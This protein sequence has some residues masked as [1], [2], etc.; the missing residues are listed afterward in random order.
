VVLPKP[1]KPTAAAPN[2]PL[3]Q[4][5]DLQLTASNITGASYNW[6]GPSAYAANVQ[7]PVRANV[8]MGDAGAYYVYATVSG[9]V[10]DTDSVVVVVN[11]DPV[12]NVFPTPGASICQGKQ[13]IFTAIPTN[14]G[15]SPSYNWLVNGTATGSIGTTYSTTTLDNGDA[16]SCAM[17]STGTCATPFIDTS[18]AITMTVQPILTP[19]VT[20]TADNM[21]P[22]NGGLT[23]TFTAT[24]THGGANPEYQWKR[25][26]ADVVGATGATWGVIVNALNANEDICVVLKSS[27]E[28]AVP[29]TALSNCITTAFTG[30]GDI[31]NSKNIKI[32]PNPVKGKVIITSTERIE[33]VEISN[34]L[35]QKL[36]TKYNTTTTMQIDMSGFVGGVYI[37]KVNDS[38]I[39]RLVKE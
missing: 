38:Y 36:L 9:C 27:Y 12:V 17:T 19:T 21:P 3:C 35:G 39:S 37:I 22:W 8:Q 7:N 6:Y 1:A 24:P 31:V 5:Q 33:K 4:R 11:T 29:D 23:V 2:S 28:C 26:G 10:S 13:V 30:V 15:S 16:V 14:G 34:L 18:N 32:Y 20:M 25:N